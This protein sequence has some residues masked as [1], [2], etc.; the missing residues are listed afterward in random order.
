MASIHNHGL[1][2]WCLEQG[3]SV[4]H[5]NFASRIEPILETAA[6]GC[7]IAT[8]E[9]LRSKGASITGRLLPKAVQS[10]ADNSPRGHLSDEDDDTIYQEH[11]AMVRHLIEAG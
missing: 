2:E 10:A 4:Q 8:F 7:N 6:A 9:L 11:V 5:S 3:T 1:V